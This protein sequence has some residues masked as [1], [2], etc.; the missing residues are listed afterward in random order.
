MTKKILIVAIVVFVVLGSVF[1]SLLILNQKPSRPVGESSRLMDIYNEE[2]AN[3]QVTAGATVY[4]IDGFDSNELELVSPEAGALLIENQ[5]NQTV[6][7]RM[8]GIPSGYSGNMSVAPIAAGD[9]GTV[10]F[11]VPGLYQIS[12]TQDPTHKITVNFVL[13]EEA[14]R[15][16]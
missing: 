9:V 10:N 7:V 1:A 16:N 13:S 15:L 6:T 2:Y 14:E 4:T 8:S 3:S 11:P 5:T 12:N